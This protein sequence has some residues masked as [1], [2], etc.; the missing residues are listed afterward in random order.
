MQEFKIYYHQST[1]RPMRFRRV[2]LSNFY[3]ALI[4]K[5]P[6]LLSP[7]EQHL[8]TFHKSDAIKLTTEYANVYN[9]K[10]KEFLALE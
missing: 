6:N 5:E 2:G 9:Q 1:N 7:I 3:T 4:L 8:G 10:L